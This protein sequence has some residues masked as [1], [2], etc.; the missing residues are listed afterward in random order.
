MQFLREAA[1]G[2]R[3]G[4]NPYSRSREWTCGHEGNGKDGTDR[5]NGIHKH[6]LPSVKQIAMG[7]YWITQG[8][9]P[10]AL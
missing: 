4:L 7:S 9:Q 6:T 10:G 3:P 1:Q 2:E 5:K 8:A